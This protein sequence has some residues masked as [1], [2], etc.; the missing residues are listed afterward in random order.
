VCLFSKTENKR[1]IWGR[2]TLKSNNYRPKPIVS[3]EIKK[4]GKGLEVSTGDSLCSKRKQV[5]KKRMEK[6]GK[7]DV[8]IKIESFDAIIIVACDESRK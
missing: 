7:G 1:G 6:V 5:V 4:R 8:E 2:I 3:L